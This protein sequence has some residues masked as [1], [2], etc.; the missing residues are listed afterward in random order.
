MFKIFMIILSTL[1]FIWAIGPFHFSF[2]HRK[3]KYIKLFVSDGIGSGNYVSR[4]VGWFIRKNEGFFV[5]GA[6][7]KIESLKKAEKSPLTTKG[8]LS[9][10]ENIK[11]G[12]LYIFDEKNKE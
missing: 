11:N 3:K 8:E 12:N 10:C 1:L 5:H 7:E 9:L 6:D 4:R 2:K